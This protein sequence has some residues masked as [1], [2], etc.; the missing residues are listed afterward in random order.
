MPIEIKVTPPGLTMSQGRTFMVTAA[1]GEINPHSSQGVYVMDTR[2]VSSYQL[3]V[4]WQPWKLVNSSQI[5]FFS[6]RIYLTNPA[7][8]AEDGDLAENSLDLTIDRYVDEGIHEDFSL[9]NY[10]GK[11]V[12]IILAL[13]I[14]CD[15]ADLFEVRA[16]RFV[17]RGKI[18]SRWNEQERSLRTSY[19][20]QDFLTMSTDYTYNIFT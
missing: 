15:F 1:N 19:T 17:L 12:K 7:L 3:Y 18:N 20:N 2:F 9:T 11:Q 10:S 4:N 14:L 16:Q 8:A 6:S 13:D 5:T